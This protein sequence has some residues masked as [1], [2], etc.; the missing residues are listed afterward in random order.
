MTDSSSMPPDA[1][2]VRTTPVFTHESVPS[3]L[4]AEHRVA[5]NTWAVLNVAS[6]RLVFVFDDRH[7]R[8]LM[9][10][11]DSQLIPPERSHH[12]VVDEPVSFAI[13]FYRAGAD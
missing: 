3:G 7:D 10:A 2:Y 1:V 5:R 11:G 13:D 4:L 8:R 12:L 9:G 6:G